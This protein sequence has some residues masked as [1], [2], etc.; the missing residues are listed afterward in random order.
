MSKIR[1]EK[2]SF[3]ASKIVSKPAKVSFHTRDGR[4]ISFKAHK[5]VPRSV[6]VEFFAE[7]KKK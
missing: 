2:V 1:R 6:K 5:D 3:R 7:R 4:E